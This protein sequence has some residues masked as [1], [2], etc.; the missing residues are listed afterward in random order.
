LRAMHFLRARLFACILLTW[1]RIAALLPPEQNGVGRFSTDPETIATQ[2]AAWF[3]SDA[4][5]LASMAR[6]AKA[7]GRPD[8]TARIVRDLAALMDEGSADARARERER[9]L[10][11]SSSSSASSSAYDLAHLVAG[12]AVKMATHARAEAGRLAALTAGWL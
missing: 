3:G 8:A 11:R 5:E 9:E 4:S 12:D 6:A 1:Q 7:L 2:V 10:A